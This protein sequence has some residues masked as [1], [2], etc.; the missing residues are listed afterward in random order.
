MHLP[1]NLG[2]LALMSD[3]REGEFVTHPFER[4][5]PLAISAQMIDFVRESK[6]P[7]RGGTWLTEST[8]RCVVEGLSKEGNLTNCC[9]IWF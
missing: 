9:T 8:K 7:G 3:A 4:P 1:P 6:K 2:L 5:K